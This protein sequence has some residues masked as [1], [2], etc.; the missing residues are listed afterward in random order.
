MRQRVVIGVGALSCRV[1]L[2]VAL[3]GAAAAWSPAGDVF[4][5]SGFS[6][7]RDFFSQLPYEHI[8]PLTGNLLMT[9]TD[10]TLPGNAG[11]DVSIQ[12]TY[13]SKIYRNYN[14]SGETLGEDSWAGVGWTL[15][16]GRVLDPTAAAPVVEMPDG[17]R[18]KTYSHLTLN[19]KR[20]TR[21]YWVYDKRGSNA[22]DPAILQLPSGVVYS[23]GRDVTLGTGERF[24][25]ATKIQDPFGNRIEIDYMTG[26]SDPKDGIEVVRQYIGA[27]QVR[28]VRFAYDTLASH[29][30]LS[31]MQ[32]VVGGSVKATWTYTSTGI[33]TTAYGLL[34]A[35][36]PPVG[37]KWLF[38]YMTTPLNDGDPSDGPKHALK[39]LT[40]PHGG[41]VSYQYR[42]VTFNIGSTVPVRTPTV[43]QRTTSGRDVAIGT[44]TYAYA[45]GA[46]KN[47]TVITSPCATTTTQTFL[48]VGTYTV[49]GAAWK[50]GLL[51]SKA[52][53]DGSL[54]FE[55]EALTWRTPT[56]AERISNDGETIGINNDVGI[57]VPLVELRE[58]S[59]DGRSYTTTNT[60]HSTDFN[61]FGRPYQVG[62]T[63]ELSRTTTR[64]FKYGF[65]PYIVDR[66]DTESVSVGG[67]SFET[68][69]DYNLTN[70]FK[71]SQTIYEI[72]TSYTP[73]L[74][75]NVATATDA[76]GFT[77]SYTYDWGVLKNTTT[78]EYLITRVINSVGTV[79]SQ[80]RRGFTTSFAYDTL[81]RPTLVTPPIGNAT[82]T[83]Y[84]NTGAT[85][86]KV[87]RGSSSTTTNLDGF[88]RP[89]S[90]S[91][92][93]G[94]KTDAS[95]DACGRRSFESYPYTGA[96]SPLP[97][98]TY[99]YDPL[100]RVTLKTDPGNISGTTTVRYAYSA[101]VDVDV[102]DENLHVTQQDWSAFGDPGDARLMA[103]R[104]AE[105]Y[106][107]SY[108]YNALGNLKSVTPPSG[109]GRQ[110]AYYGL[111][112]AGGSHGLL[113]S[114]T[115]PENGS[116]TY[117]YYPA[118]NV[119]QRTDAKAQTTLFTY[120]GNTRLTF[121]D[122]AGTAYDTTIGYD[123]S[124][125]RTS[126]GN[127]FVASTFTYDGGNRLTQRKDVVNSKTLTTIY[128][129]DPNDNIGT[130]T[131]PS[132]R[133]V[134]YGYDT[135]NRISSV[136][137]GV[138]NALYASSF[139]YHPSGAPTAFTFGSGLVRGFAFNNRYRQKQASVATGT[140]NYT[141]DPAG[142]VWTIDDDRAGMDQSFTYDKVDRLWTV[143]GLGA[144]SF[145]YYATGN[146]RTKTVG[147]ATTTYSYD[148]TTNH[149]A[150]ASGAEPD[151]LGYDSNGNATSDAT[152][153]YNY[154]S[155][156][157]LELATIGGLT[158][159]YRY[160]GDGLRKRKTSPT[161]ENRYYVH[162]PGGQ[163]LGEY[164][165]SCTAGVRSVQDSVYAGTRLLAFLEPAPTIALAA[166]AGSFAEN[167]GSASVN[168]VLTTPDGCPTISPVTLTYATANGTAVGGADYTPA[169]GL[170]SFPAGTASGSA[171][172][173]GVGLLN[174]PTI[175]ANETFSVTL[176]GP[177]GASLGTP[178]TQ[179]VTIV[180]NDTPTVSFVSATSTVRENGVWVSALPTVSVTTQDGNNLTAAA[181][182]SYATAAISGGA[183]AGTDYTT[184]SGIL[185]F[186]A[187]RP[188]GDT[189]TIGVAILQDS[190][191]EADE[192]FK[193]NLSL[194]VGASLG[195]PTSD[196]VTIL[197]DDAP[198]QF[199]L[200]G[201]SVSEGAA[202]G[203]PATTTATLNVVLKDTN[204]NPKNATSAVTVSYATADGT[205][206]AGKDYVA[207]SGTLTIQVGQSSAPLSVTI[208][209]D[210][211][212]ELDDNET[213]SVT[214]SNPVNAS[215]GLPLTHTL[216]VQDNDP[217]PTVASVG[218]VSLPEGDGG[219]Q[220][221][222]FVVALSNPSESSL[223]WQVSTCYSIVV[224]PEIN[225]GPGAATAYE[226]YA[227][228]KTGLVSFAPEETQNTFD[229]TVYGDTIEELDEG[230]P[231]YVK[232][233]SGEVI[234]SVAGTILNDDG[235]GTSLAAPP[236]GAKDAGVAEAQG[237]GARLIGEL[238]FTI[239]QSGLYR[240][241][242]DLSTGIGSGA[243]IAIEADK[244]Q[245]D[246]NGR[247]IGSTAGTE[248][249]AV[250]ILASG[251]RFVTVK[252]GAV[253]GF[254]T[255]VRLG[256]G[257]NQVVQDVVVEAARNGIEVGGGG[258]LVGRNRVVGSGAATGG[259]GIL[260]HGTDIHVLDNDVLDTGSASVAIRIQH[261]AQ[262]S[263]SANRIGNA[264]S[265]DVAGIAVVDMAQGEVR[266][267]RI[268]SSA[269]G[270]ELEASSCEV[271]G[272]V[273]SGVVV[274]YVENAGGN[275]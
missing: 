153:G 140:L 51:A 76:N 131:Y 113:K 188:S 7:N 275:Q 108:T 46:S 44:W 156:N 34:T 135:E 255:G 252:N 272:N 32:L 98:T 211:L 73:D 107:T 17:S 65:T 273:M 222:G 54:T 85:Y 229:V 117:T 200:S 223:S 265:E 214:L 226:D 221:F 6:R 96:P 12:R 250:G 100:G 155:E 116:V 179:T 93:V 151:S 139:T 101:G 172:T 183:S 47:Q 36:T 111:S 167:A 33:G 227:H 201:S 213:F 168:V 30:S 269:V 247:R 92:S 169:S 152:G 75:G 23:F 115:N 161:G 130:I 228:V 271:S 27:S 86:V 120:D 97:G 9:F 14:A 263:V 249:A 202:P 110:W 40:T 84:D 268:T 5:E 64:V 56:F 143:T 216:T 232:D 52:T 102:T 29:R 2:L 160:D 22:A 191:V 127:G 210:T 121:A 19:P 215:L 150:S 49:A 39:S 154:T 118:G 178:A 28:E 45:Q 170:L 236:T 190:L 198:V 87:T 206:L 180:D 203:S 186:A 185:T 60:Y 173:I 8:D 59:R 80:T 126:L 264:L 95:Y 79:A 242:G 182:V 50:V 158:T 91:N 4:N 164:T 68:S 134:T 243:A 1:G 15:H 145:D 240:L 103:V 260:A 129:P 207:A 142:N 267:N 90:S 177:T 219:S 187:G 123:D 114:E 257:A 244:V 162:G 248:G 258:A 48:G 146:R 205:A 251:R 42:E 77:T 274:P 62:E 82:G 63:G 57:Y 78:P 144:G 175:E 20:I 112:E 184:K 13:N 234:S 241:S 83:T 141:Y 166:S 69:F 125:N 254:A 128:T 38:S 94:V 194:P 193:L 218:S 266:E 217:V 230:F 174:D 66:V 122:R 105:D 43:Y 137:D 41:V 18:H 197:D 148:P 209:N 72:T 195:P 67:E 196:T 165:D 132:G 237:P 171:Q 261:G 204:G 21:E 35:V 212:D 71:K 233:A 176:S 24:L 138:T 238:P 159:T 239:T 149:L 31:Q 58:I 259:T 81:F 246:L 147:A 124:D 55:T 181:K 74:Y 235:G 109:P 270:V 262:C 119:K 199:E 231:F 104:D 106:T 37:P 89:S 88:G 208:L 133:K 61:D 253:S 245:L 224:C 99:G 10:L 136:K 225:D 53:G 256:E 16:L 25:Y 3:F 192:A 163:L 157:M 11:F 189:Q 220:P 26:A 70:G